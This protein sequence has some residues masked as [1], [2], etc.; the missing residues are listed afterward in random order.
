MEKYFQIKSSKTESENKGDSS[1][2]DGDEFSGP[3]LQYIPWVEKYRPAKIDE[4]AHQE[5]VLAILRS[6]LK[7]SDVPHMLFYGPPGTGKTTTILAFC[8]ELYG[9]DF[10]RER[11]LELN[12]SDERGISVVR[13]KIKTFAGTAVSTTRPDGTPCPSFK[14]VILDEA[15]SMTNAAQ[16]ALRRTME[17]HSKST[18]FCLICNY[19]SRIIDPITSRCAKFRFK[20]L[21]E[22]HMSRR[23][24]MIS[25]NESVDIN[26]E[27][28]QALLEFSEGDMRKSITFLQCVAKLRAGQTIVKEDILEVSGC[29]DQSVIDN[30]IKISFSGSFDQAQCFIQQVIADG[31]AANQLLS[32]LHD[33]II[34]NE[35]LG[36]SQKAKVMEKISLCDK[37]LM[38]GACEYFQLLDVTCEMMKCELS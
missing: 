26:E 28:I 22:E 14:V 21:S 37:R 24:K 2:D 8:K 29:I 13:H 18:R 5:E 19:V 36:D 27:A 38:D 20:P 25:D 17:V 10:W 3:V 30:W 32:Q 9:V 34:A 11:V 6:C 23:L 1:T 15:D 33:A 12:A 35:Q 16:S 7:G 31:F 4:V